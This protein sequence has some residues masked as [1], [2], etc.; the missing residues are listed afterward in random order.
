MRDYAEAKKMPQTITMMS[1]VQ[2][3]DADTI[4]IDEPVVMPSADVCATLKECLG[5]ADNRGDGT[6]TGTDA[7]KEIEKKETVKSKLNAKVSAL[8]TK[9]GPPSATRDVDSNGSAIGTQLEAARTK[10]T[11][12]RKDPGSVPPIM[13]SGKPMPM[14]TK[15]PEYKS[16]LKE[17]R[18]ASGYAVP[19]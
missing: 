14:F 19:A 12:W 2:F 7:V 13:T 6:Y 1:N 11:E 4:F 10:V 5:C 9:L 3:T 15:L 18:G 8:F 16:F 17:L